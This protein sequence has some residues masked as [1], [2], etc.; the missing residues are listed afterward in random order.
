[1]SSQVE[2]VKKEMCQMN[3]ILRA[4]ERKLEKSL[5]SA[6]V[7]DFRKN[8]FHFLRNKDKTCKISLL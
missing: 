3:A 6:T 4:R 5:L 2:R 1:M 8:E 7:V